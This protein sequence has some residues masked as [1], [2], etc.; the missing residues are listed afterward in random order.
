MYK[1]RLLCISYVGG[2]WSVGLFMLSN[3]RQN[4]S[5]SYKRKI[6]LTCSGSLWFRTRGMIFFLH[7]KLACTIFSKLPHLPVLPFLICKVRTIAFSRYTVRKKYIKDWEIA[8]VV[9][10]LEHKGAKIEFCYWRLSL[11]YWVVLLIRAGW[12]TSH[13]I[14]TDFIIQLSSEPK[15]FLKI[16]VLTMFLKE[17]FLWCGL[18]TSVISRDRGHAFQSI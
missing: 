11:K 9:Q 18:D 7:C 5:G 6:T 16:S 12:N 15:A 8:L 17:R 1:G 2:E 4:L 3:S 10:W 13:Q 14:H